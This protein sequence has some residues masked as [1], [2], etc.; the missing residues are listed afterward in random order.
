MAR[1]PAAAPEQYVPLFGEAAPL[2]LQVYAHNPPLAAACGEF[3]EALSEHRTL[4]ARLIELVRLRIAFHNQCRT[5]MA[6]R[7]VD[8]ADEGV[9]EDLVCS[10]ERPA[11]A[12]DLTEA[13][14]AAIAFGD[15][16]ATD[17]FAID[18][19][20]FERLREHFDEAQIMELCINVAFL[21][22]FG[23]MSMALDMTDDLP[24]RFRRPGERIVPWGPGEVRR[25]AGWTAA[26]R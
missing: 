17:H 10:L 4:P 25:E 20:T 3:R 19:S 11:E 26:G 5:C 24:E 12:P 7:Y 18:D 22:G 15:L 13:E 16:M 9:D 6:V 14:R 8:A 23:R 2:R 1:V 21:V